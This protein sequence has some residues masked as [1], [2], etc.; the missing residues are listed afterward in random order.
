MCNEADL[1]L[2]GKEEFLFLNNGTNRIIEQI[3]GKY[4]FPNDFHPSVV[5]THNRR[6]WV[7]QAALDACY[8]HIIA[9]SKEVVL[10]QLLPDSVDYKK[11]G[12][13]PIEDY[14]LLDSNKNSFYDSQLLQMLH[15]TTQAYPKG[16]T[17]WTHKG[18]FNYIK[19]AL[20]FFKQQP[21]LELI[22]KLDLHESE[23]EQKGDL[24]SKIAAEPDSFPQLRTKKTQA[25]LI[26]N[27][28]TQNEG[29]LRIW[30]NEDLKEQKTKLLLLHDS[31][32]MWLFWL[33]PEIF[34]EVIAIHTSDL[35]I[36]Y[37]INYKPTH[38]LF[39]QT[40]RFFTRKPSNDINWLQ[41]LDNE[42]N[43][44]SN[45]LSGSWMLKQWPTIN[46]GFYNE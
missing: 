34:S 2:F 24:A 13:L 42:A 10:N 25:K 43:K 33:F 19:A 1:V 22:K 27:N 46:K 6:R 23:G 3:E 15:I 12:N 44:K 45:L 21:L 30:L 5:E 16:D 39:L 9:P 11:Y 31:S 37:L 40:E 17:H 38:V 14:L 41:F 18:A 35:D 28:A 26:F 29:C 32:A 36:N 4:S 8:M 20:N 7:C